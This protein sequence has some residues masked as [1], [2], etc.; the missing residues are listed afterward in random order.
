LLRTPSEAWLFDT[1]SQNDFRRIIDPAL[2][3]AGLIRLNAL[4]VT[5][6]DADHIGGAIAAL[7]TV[8]PRR[9]ID[10]ALRD[11]SRARRNLHARIASLGAA[12]SLAFPGDFDR[13]GAETIVRILHPLP[14]E[15]VRSADDQAIVVRLEMDGFRILLMSDSGAATENNLVLRHGD[16]LRSDVVVLGRHGE[17]I[18]ATESFLRAAKPR[19]IILNRI[20]PFRDGSDEPALRSRLA[21][22]GAQ[23]FDQEKTGAVILTATRGGLEIRGY[24][25]GQAVTLRT[26]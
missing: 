16:D 10:T 25:D 7:E 9:L 22:S 11:R 18:I 4:V 6:G 13:L 19:V 15:E 23:I 21:A 20:D 1:G 26:R 17:D 2:R 24:L 8:R 3:A 5:H 14:G 12:K